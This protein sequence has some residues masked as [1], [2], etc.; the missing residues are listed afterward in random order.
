[1]TVQEKKYF[2][3]FLFYCVWIICIW[4]SEDNSVR[5]ALS[6]WLH[7]GIQAGVASAYIS[8]LKKAIM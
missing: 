1:M 2:F 8:V 5:S 6:F 7:M 4:R 3:P